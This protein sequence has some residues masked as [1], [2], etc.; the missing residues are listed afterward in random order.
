MPLLLKKTHPEEPTATRRETR[1]R[2]ISS[3]PS[4]SPASAKARIASESRK[5]QCPK[6]GDLSRAW[7]QWLNL[8]VGWMP[9]MASGGKDVEQ[10][11]KPPQKIIRLQKAVTRVYSWGD[12]FSKTPSC[13]LLSGMGVSQ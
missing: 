7:D 4:A 1:L 8:K 5:R 10:I 12:T 6:C 9:D 3:A 2:K 11:S 13:Y